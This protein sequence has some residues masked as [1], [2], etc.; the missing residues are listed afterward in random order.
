VGRR[1]PLDQI[2]EAIADMT[3]GRLAGRAIIHFSNA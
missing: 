3:S 1:Y 2:N